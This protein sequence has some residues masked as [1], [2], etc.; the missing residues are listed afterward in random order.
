MQGINPKRRTIMAVAVSIDKSNV[1]QNEADNSVQHVRGSFTL[2]GNYGGSSTHGDTV[3]FSSVYGIQSRSKPLKVEV[4][5]APNKGTLPTGYIFTYC[6]GTS[7]ADGV[8]NICT[9]IGTELTQA[10]AYAAGLTGA[11]IKFEALFPAFV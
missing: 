1:A 4:Y 7:A 9:A 8:L 11:A 3:N 6:P 5:E 10:S 2:S